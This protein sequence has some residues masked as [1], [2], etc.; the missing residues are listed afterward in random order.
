MNIELKITQT[1]QSKSIKSETDQLANEVRG[2]N[3]L[4]KYYFKALINYYLYNIQKF[5]ILLQEAQ[6]HSDRIKKKQ[7]SVGLNCAYYKK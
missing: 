5:R 7:A 2:N 3:D 1:L 6:S 4:I